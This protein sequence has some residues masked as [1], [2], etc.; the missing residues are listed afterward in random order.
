MVSEVVVCG[1][2]NMDVI[3]QSERR[4]KAGETILGATVS[5]LPGG[6]AILPLTGTMPGMGTIG[7]GVVL[8][9]TNDGGTLAASGERRKQPEFRRIV[10]VAHV[11]AQPPAAFDAMPAM[12]P[13]CASRGAPASVVA[14]R[15]RAGACAASVAHDGWRAADVHTAQCNAESAAGSA[16]S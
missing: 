8:V 11:H 5:L 15:T 4:P 2:L 3:V 16:I 9:V 7:K 12:S 14:L 10:D 13:M 6:K 1:S